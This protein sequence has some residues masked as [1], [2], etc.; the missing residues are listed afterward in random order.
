MID[1]LASALA[2]HA[3]AADDR[4]NLFAKFRKLVHS[5]T[6]HPNGPKASFDVEVKWK[7]AALIG[8][9]VFPQRRYSGGRVV[10]EE[11]FEPPT[12]GL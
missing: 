1:S 2:D 6:I 5:I 10:A 12:Q 3:K 8:G 9:Q 4:G 11:G 7:L